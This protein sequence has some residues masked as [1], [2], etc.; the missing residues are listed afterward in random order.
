MGAISGDDGGTEAALGAIVGRFD[1][2][3][4][5]EAQDVASIVLGTDAIKKPL[6][7]SIGEDSIAK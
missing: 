6:I 2:R 5:K 3:S 1:F 7:A 4:V